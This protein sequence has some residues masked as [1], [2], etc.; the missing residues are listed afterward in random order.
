MPNRERFAILFD[1]IAK[2]LFHLR[3]ARASD[4]TS[5]QREVVANLRALRLL[6]GLSR[7]RFAEV[8]RLGVKNL[9][10]RERG[11]NAW[12]QSEVRSALSA[13]TGHL[14]ESLAEVESLTRKFSPQSTNKIV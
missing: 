12:P 2:T 4:M 7:A 8:I 6:T 14:K 9:E 1:K 11:N 3:M 13:L 5:K 10:S